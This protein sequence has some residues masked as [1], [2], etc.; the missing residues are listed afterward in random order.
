[1][2]T[3]FRNIALV[4]RQSD[5]RVA[6]PM[7]V[8]ADY[9]TKAGI[10]VTAA[11]ALALDLHVTHVPEEQLCDNANL[12][13]AIG[14]DGTMLYASRLARISGTPI[15]G[16]NRGRLGFLADI[17]PDAMIASVD[18]VL[19][20]RYLKDSR[21]LLKASLSTAAG[22]EV[23][24]YGLNDV[25]VQ[26]RGSGGMVDFSTSVAGRYVNTHSGDGLIC[27]T[28]TGSTAYALSCG[29]PIIEPQ[30]DAVALV[31][32]CPHTLTDRPI[33][34]PASQE[35]EILLLE[36]DDSRAEITVDGGHIGTLGP[37]DRLKVAAASQRITLLHP[38]GH[39]FYGI[40]RSKLFWGRDSRK[41]GI[42]TS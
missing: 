13:I 1:M 12:V 22:D 35:I 7:R 24:Q 4:G 39:D 38:P 17:T 5:A 6:E 33:V 29:G 21:L 16:V 26:R 3:E 20:G 36:R 28:P 23:V 9:L 15:L 37:G 25:V 8:L 14:G 31:P 18:Q 30:L 41:R 32:I 2:D 11:E 27:A 19:A 34:I 42:E 10:N 40:L